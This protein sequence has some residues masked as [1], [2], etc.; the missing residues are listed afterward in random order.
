MSNPITLRFFR[1]T[2]LAAAL[3][4]GFAL[5]QTN[6]VRAA[7]GPAAGPM[8]QPRGGYRILAPIESGSLLLFPVVQS[9]K[10]PGSPAF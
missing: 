1:F 5:H 9:G 7:A 3:I 2:L 6:G 8:E 4:A 10:M